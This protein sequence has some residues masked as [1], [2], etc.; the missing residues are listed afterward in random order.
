MAGCAHN[1]DVKGLTSR[2]MSLLYGC[3]ERYLFIAN[4]DPNHPYNDNRYVADRPVMPAFMHSTYVFRILHYTHTR[5]WMEYENVQ[6]H[7]YDCA[8]P[9]N[10]HAHIFKV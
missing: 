7:G 10:G 9:E 2:I 8:A 5:I 1:G 3:S 6:T 4:T